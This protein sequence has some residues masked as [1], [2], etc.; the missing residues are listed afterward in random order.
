VLHGAQ[1][2]A[3]AVRVTLGPKSKSELIERKYGRP[4]PGRPRDGHCELFPTRRGIFSRP[5][6]LARGPVY[7]RG[8]TEPFRARM[9]ASVVR[10]RGGLLAGRKV[11]KAKGR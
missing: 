8:P 7:L 3:D 6:S 5:A 11:A 10:W 4:L 9:S 2:L 1:A